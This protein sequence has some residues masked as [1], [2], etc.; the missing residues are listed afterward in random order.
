VTKYG[1]KPVNKYLKWKYDICAQNE[2]GSHRDAK[3]D[4]VRRR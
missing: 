1:L 2:G 4:E 3:A